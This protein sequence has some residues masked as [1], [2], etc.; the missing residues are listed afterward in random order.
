MLI[1]K[2]TLKNFLSYGEEG[3]DILLH[4]LNI[5]IGANGSGKSNLL[6]AISLLRST[7]EKI[8]LPVHGGGGVSEWLWKGGREIPEAS[9]TA[10]LSNP[11]KP[12]DYPS[13]RYMFNFTEVNKR[14]EI[15]EEVIEDEAP[16]DSSRDRSYFYYSHNRFS[17]T[18][19]AKIGKN[20]RSRKLQREE[21]DPESSI[22]AQ[23]KEPDI[24][25]E[26]T[27]LGN[28]FAKIKI[29]REWHF[30]VSCAVRE[31]QDIGIGA[32]QLAENCQNLPL[33]I[34]MLRDNFSIRTQLQKY[35]QDIYDGAFDVDVKID[36]GKA[37]T[38]VVEKNMCSAIPAK[39]LSDGTLRYLC[40]LAILLN[41]TPPPLICIDEPEL[42][43][44][45]D[46]INNLAKLL[47]EASTRTQ[48]IVNTHSS[49]LLNAFSDAPEAVIICEKA[50]GS[51]SLNR[52]R[53][54]DVAPLLKDHLLGDLWIRGDLG[55][56]RW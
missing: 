6:E 42:G 12:L 1:K 40:L 38:V 37:T 47:K 23:R 8:A 14:F 20:T 13:L 53:E 51:T 26:I 30:G 43:M 32:E 17:T 45:P 29:Y 33:V 39:R 35:V 25:P 44:H 27:Y 52:L 28:V 19:N 11:F 48:I 50:N 2:L 36:A 10:L 9:I 24:Y 18:I 22:L 34:N 56:N 4:D 21:I 31:S 54:E 16:Y 3:K 5:I 41:P 15:T 46:L 55:G 49:L 7:P